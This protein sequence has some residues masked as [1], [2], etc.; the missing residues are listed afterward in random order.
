MKESLKESLGHSRYRSLEKCKVY[1][2]IIPMKE[3]DR[4]GSLK[5]HRA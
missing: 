3:K 2:N 1:I 4:K 5:L